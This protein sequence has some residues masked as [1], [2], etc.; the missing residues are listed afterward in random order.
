MTAALFRA[1]LRGA[2][3]PK[4]LGGR[5]SLYS[6]FQMQTARGQTTMAVTH[7]SASR[8]GLP[9]C[10]VY[11]TT[12]K[13]SAIVLSRR[14]RAIDRG[15]RFGTNL[16]AQQWSSL[17]TNRPARGILKSCLG[18]WTQTPP[19]RQTPPLLEDA[20]ESE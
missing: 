7:S 1:K 10:P 4:L 8:V 15:V 18:K 5:S 14:V 2:I 19:C 11:R 3:Y 9:L 6:S 17:R 12:D 20:T 13:I 16:E